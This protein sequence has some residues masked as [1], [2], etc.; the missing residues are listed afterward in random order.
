MK[1]LKIAAQIALGGDQCRNYLLAAVIKRKDGAVVVSTNA[2]TKLPQ[3]AAHAEAR[4]LRKA[5]V[6]CEMYVARV[7]RDGTWALAKPC[8]HCQRL[9]RSKGVKRVYYTIAP[10]EWGVWDVGKSKQP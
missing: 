2:L 1:L 3:P 7:L 10:N 9:I 8:R 5:D 6:G 4:A